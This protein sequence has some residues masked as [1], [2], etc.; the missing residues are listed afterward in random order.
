MLQLHENHLYNCAN[1][2][3]FDIDGIYGLNPGYRLFMVSENKADLAIETEKFKDQSKLKYF[4]M[5]IVRQLYEFVLL[6]NHL[7]E[8]QY[9]ALSPTKT[10]FENL[11]E[12]YISFEVLDSY[13]QK[14]LYDYFTCMFV[15]TRKLSLLKKYKFQDLETYNLNRQFKT[16]AFIAGISAFAS[17]AAAIISFISLQSVQDININNKALQVEAVIKTMP[18]VKQN[19]YNNTINVTK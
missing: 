4:H 14:K 16:T 1:N 2:I 15:P 12:G 18:E 13:L 7:V 11:W 8:N 17:I 6:I 10:Q 19:Y 5:E 9:I 3:L